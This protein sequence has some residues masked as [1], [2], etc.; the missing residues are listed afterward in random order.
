MRTFAA[1]SRAR[2]TAP[3]SSAGFRSWR[4]HIFSKGA[5]KG[6]GEGRP[7]LKVRRE[8]DWESNCGMGQVAYGPVSTS[9]EVVA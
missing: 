3:R 8:S 9:S 6:A 2:M 7:T 4:Q 1:S 5:G